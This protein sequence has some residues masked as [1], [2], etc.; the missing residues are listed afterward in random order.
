M[1]KK[2]IIIYSS[3]GFLKELLEQSHPNCEITQYTSFVF[4]EI[5][6]QTIVLIDDV[7]VLESEINALSHLCFIIILGKKN[8]LSFNNPQLKYIDKPFLYSDLIRL[9]NFSNTNLIT[10]SKNIWINAN[11]KTLVKF[12]KKDMRALYLTKKE[13]DLIIYIVSEDNSVKSKTDILRN[14]FGYI[15]QVSTYTLE[16]H[17]SR[18]RKKLEPEVTIVNSSD[19]Y[20]LEK[21]KTLKKQ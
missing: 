20:Y 21:E 11:S 14:V 9:I 1:T 17:I 16:T 12:I 3:Y 13:M 7:I 6:T 2:N 8:A 4:P 15:E 10:L 18:L 5:K 19:G